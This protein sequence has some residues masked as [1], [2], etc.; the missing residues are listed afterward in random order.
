MPLEVQID[1]ANT[2]PPAIQAALKKMTKL[3]VTAQDGNARTA[4]KATHQLRKLAWSHPELAEDL[5]LTMSAPEISRVLKYGCLCGPVVLDEPQWKDAASQQMRLRHDM[6]NYLVEGSRALYK[7][8]I[9]DLM[10]GENFRAY[11]KLS[12]EIDEI[13]RQLRVLNAESRSKEDSPEKKAILADL[14]EKKAARKEIAPAVGPEVREFYKRGVYLEIMKSKGLLANLCTRGYQKYAALGLYHTNYNPCVQDFATA[15]KATFKDTKG[16]LRGLQPRYGFRNG[17]FPSSITTWDEWDG[18]GQTGITVTN[19]LA[20]L[21]NDPNRPNPD[22]ALAGVID[23]TNGFFRLRPMRQEDVQHFPIRQKIDFSRESSKRLYIAEIRVVGP[24]TAGH[25]VFASIPVILHRPLPEGGSL[26]EAVIDAKKDGHRL[27]HYLLVTVNFT[28]KKE[29]S[30]KGVA[31]LTMGEGENG[32]FG[33]ATR[34]S[35]TEFSKWA[36]GD[37]GQRFDWLTPDGILKANSFV[38]LAEDRSHGLDEV[39]TEHFKQAIERLRVLVPTVKLPDCVA[40]SDLD[41]TRRY[42]IRRMYRVWRTDVLTKAAAVSVEEGEK[43]QQVFRTLR[44]T[45]REMVKQDWDLA[46]N[47]VA[48]KAEELLNLPLDVAQ[49]FAILSVVTERYDHLY[50]WSC[51]VRNRSLRRR[52]DEYRQFAVHFLRG[53]REVHIPGTNKKKGR[54]I[55]SAGQRYMAAASLLDAIRHVA[56]R[57]GIAVIETK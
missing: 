4:A 49:V 40:S 17:E 48:Y 47:T 42:G 13:Y 8:A 21:K 11:H 31:H 44:Q 32:E 22:K 30:G 16:I 36:K 10:K 45:G 7:L 15:F 27:K 46:V 53:V 9:D 55:M 28:A 26:C 33:R 2:P 43:A 12:T 3:Q 35:T 56:E 23:G 52:C 41:V 1:A 50:P 20:P 51:N 6:Y 37:N 57:E 25:P 14:A 19:K 54:Q 24:N 34:T 5:N 38:K 29:L 39:V 18:A